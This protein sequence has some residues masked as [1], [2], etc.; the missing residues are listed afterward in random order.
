[1]LHKI[2]IDR[3]AGKGVRKFKKASSCLKLN[4]ASIYSKYLLFSQE[5]PY[6]K[7]D[8]NRIKRQTALNYQFV[9]HEGRLCMFVN[10]ELHDV[11]TLSPGSYVYILTENMFCEKHNAV[12]IMFFINIMRKRC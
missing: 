10:L 2:L 12:G 8:R 3:F 5:E 11:P 9:L 7:V 4:Y 1:M 6:L